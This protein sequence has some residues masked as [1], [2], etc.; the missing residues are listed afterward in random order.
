MTSIYVVA[1]HGIASQVVTV[2]S[3]ATRAHALA[4]ALNAQAAPDDYFEA[5][6]EPVDNEA[7]LK[8]IYE[9]YGLHRNIAAGG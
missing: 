2:L 3:D 1:R 5:T 8:D 7:V 4:K 9:A 6:R